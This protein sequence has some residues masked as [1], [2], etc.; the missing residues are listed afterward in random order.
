MSVEIS[1][2]L[3]IVVAGVPPSLRASAQTK[4]SWRDRIR[5]AARPSLPEGHWTTEAPVEV[6]IYY[7]LD[8]PMIGDLDNIVK[9]ILDSLSQFVLADDSQVERLVIQRFEPDRVVS[10]TNPS[11]ELIRALFETAGSRVYVRI[12]VM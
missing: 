3:E 7:F 5:E 9:P 1:F 10:F 4:V 2:P 11:A 8:A 6:T 12:D